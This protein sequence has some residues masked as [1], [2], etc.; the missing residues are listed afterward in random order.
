MPQT[1]NSGLWA[2][3][4]IRQ[5][6]LPR[7]HED[8]LPRS[9]E[10]IPEEACRQVKVALA[11]ITNLAT[12]I[13]DRLPLHR[14]IWEICQT[15]ERQYAEWNDIKG[16][17]PAARQQRQDLVYSLRKTRNKLASQVRVNHHVLSNNLD[18]KQVDAV[19][20]SLRKLTVAFPQ[21]FMNL[22]DAVKRYFSKRKS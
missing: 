6:A 14:S 3:E 5:D 2:L 17:T 19:Y 21:L 7:L 13:P 10:G 9:D 15:Y 11:E 22:A 16:D 1:A 12:Q 18:V 4:R 8:L 20:A